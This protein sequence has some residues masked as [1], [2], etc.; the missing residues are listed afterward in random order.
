MTNRKWVVLVCLLC[1]GVAAALWVPSGRV[2]SAEQKPDP[3]APSGRYQVVKMVSLTTN[4]VNEYLLDNATGK[5]WRL[6]HTPDKEPGK[7][8]LVAEAPK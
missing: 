1:V 7:W 4:N 3:V 5:L 6:D 8:V 2:A